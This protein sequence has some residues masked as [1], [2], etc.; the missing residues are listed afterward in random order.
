MDDL[1]GFVLPFLTK[2][3]G[4]E[5]PPAILRFG[6]SIIRLVTSLAESSHG[7]ELAR[8]QMRI[9]GYPSSTTS[10]SSSS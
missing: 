8:T 2:C 4:S 10:T 9:D 1:H 3:N 6:T 5:M 7:F